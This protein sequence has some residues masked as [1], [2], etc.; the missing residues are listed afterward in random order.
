MSC[1]ARLALLL[2]CLGVCSGGGC[3]HGRPIRHD[4]GDPP[5]TDWGAGTTGAAG[6]GGPAEAREGPA[7]GSAGGAGS[8]GA[9]GAAA[10]QAGV[11]A[12]HDTGAATPDA[13]TDTS[14]D[15]APDA[16]RDVR[17]GG[18]DAPAA[19]RPVGCEPPAA[20]KDTTVLTE[21]FESYPLGSFEGAPGSPWIRANMGRT[22]EISSAA[23]GSGTKALLLA[24]FT[25]KVE[26]YYAP[27]AIPAL[28][29]KLSFQ[30]T[31]LLDGYLQG[32][33]SQRY[34]FASFGL[35]IAHS[36]YDL[37]RVLELKM[38]AAHQLLLTTGG[39][40]K[41][42]PL[43]L[44]LDLGTPPRANTIRVEVNLCTWRA[45][46]WVG[47]G[48]VAPTL[49]TTVDILPFPAAPSAFV[50]S[51]GPSSSYID[52]VSVTVSVPP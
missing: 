50:L 28:P 23:V 25:T 8:G 40:Q 43:F 36:K 16:T 22:Q 41:D 44:E 42:V 31:A 51:G 9:D 20:L 6:T 32:S 29:P 34:D 45:E 14:A 30:L 47:V 3:R 18:A 2:A 4:A 38:T 15:T 10:D 24:S 7:A 1:R 21:G 52:D 11:V 49:R 35:G 26:T 17:A 33:D 19:P 48:A 13:M 46:I 27:L 12:A 39:T 5:G 37:E